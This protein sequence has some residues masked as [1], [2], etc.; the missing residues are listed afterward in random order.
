MVR[1][2]EREDATSDEERERGD[3]LSDERVDRVASDLKYT[4]HTDLN[5]TCFNAYIG[6]FFFNCGQLGGK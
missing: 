5:R 1:V 4:A 2:R 6:F 3:K